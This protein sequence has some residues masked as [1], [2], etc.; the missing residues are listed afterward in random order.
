MQQEPDASSFPS[1]GI[2]EHFRG[3][4]LHRMGCFITGIHCWT[5]P[6]VSLQSLSHTPV[7]HL[8]TRHRSS[9]LL[10]HLTALPLKYAIS[11]TRM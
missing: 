2:Q 5:I 1:G 3:A 7:K 4:R 9:G 11:L 8:I 6:F 10:R